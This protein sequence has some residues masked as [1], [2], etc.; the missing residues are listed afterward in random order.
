MAQHSRAS[1]DPVATVSMATV[2]VSKAFIPLHVIC[3]FFFSLAWSRAICTGPIVNHTSFLFLQNLSNHN[4]RSRL[5]QMETDG[6][7]GSSW[8][9]CSSWS[10]WEPL[11]RRPDLRMGNFFC[12][13]CSTSHQAT[14]RSTLE[15]KVRSNTFP[16]LPG[17]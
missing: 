15:R 12:E 9:S 6:I 3:L 14:S 10:H 13:A 16:I 5:K 17:G 2:S 8:I 1:I 11:H 4:A 7:S